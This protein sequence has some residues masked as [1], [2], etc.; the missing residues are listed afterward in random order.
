MLNFLI[1]SYLYTFKI[2]CSIEHGKS[3]I[4]SGP[5]D[6]NVFSIVLVIFSFIFVPQIT[7]LAF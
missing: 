2:S 1:F 3:F 6:L 7:S 5:E 4:T